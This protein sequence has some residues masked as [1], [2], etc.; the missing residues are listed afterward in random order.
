MLVTELQSNT[1]TEAQNPDRACK[2]RHHRRLT[3][4]LGTLLVNTY[5]CTRVSQTA[6]LD[7][8]DMC[9]RRYSSFVGGLEECS[10]DNLEFLK[11]KALKAMHDLLRSKPEQV[12][13]ALL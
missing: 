12:V 11:D 1:G 9:I 4:C 8:N 3:P 7:C 10:R 13:T 2:R 5:I 6:I